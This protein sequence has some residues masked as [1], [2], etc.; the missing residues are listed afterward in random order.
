M[1][2][3]IVSDENLDNR[4]WPRT[5]AIAERLWS[6]KDVQDVDSMYRRLAIVSQKLDAHGLRHRLITEEM[7]ERMSGDPDPV[8]LRVLAG[9]VQPPKGYDRQ[10]LRNFG[11]FTPL[12]HLDDAVP[13]E[14]ETARLFDAT[15][16]RIAA[17]KASAEDWKQARRWLELWRDND[18]TL[19]PLLA[20][21]SLTQDLAPVSRNLS[22]TAAIGLEALDSLQENRPLSGDVRKQNID[23]LIEAAKPHAVLLL[24][25]A[26]SVQTLVEATLTR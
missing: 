10:Q 26:P 4:V 3:D 7:L 13:P 12:N 23:F 2:T 8:A 21:S 6:P 16:K 19:Q 25:V 11:D 24:M 1:W 20:R 14:C 17:G 18:A 5:A 15:A 9:V 22:Q